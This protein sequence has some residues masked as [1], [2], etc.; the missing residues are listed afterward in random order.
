MACSAGGSATHA[1]AR[2]GFRNS[3]EEGSA[4]MKIG[5][6]SVTYLGIWYDGPASR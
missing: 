2:N 6:Y 1:H 4:A 3:V 5:L